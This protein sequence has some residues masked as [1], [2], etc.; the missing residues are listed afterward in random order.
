MLWFTTQVVGRAVEGLAVTA[1]EFFTLAIIFS[2]IAMYLCL[3]KKP[4]DVRQFITIHSK[5]GCVLPTPGSF[6]RLRLIEKIFSKANRASTIFCSSSSCPLASAPCM[7]R[8]G[9]LS[10]QLPRNSSCGKSVVLDA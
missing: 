5:G 10:A 9:T 7:S 4:Y 3:W 8:P 1:L 2:A 6:E